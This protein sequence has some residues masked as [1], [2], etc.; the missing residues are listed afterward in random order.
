[1]DGSGIWHPWEGRE[2][3]RVCIDHAFSIELWREVD[4]EASVR[5]EAPF[6]VETSGNQQRYDP[7]G[8]REL[9]A[10]ALTVFGK[11][12]E[13]AVCFDS[14]GLELVFSGGL[15]LHQMRRPRRGVERCRP[16][17]LPHCRPRQPVA[18]DMEC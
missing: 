18:G 5:I 17:R 8:P 7:E 4:R 13:R 16:G 6:V 2:V 9:L 10:E 1:M 15:T 3:T 14:G 12:V 11:T